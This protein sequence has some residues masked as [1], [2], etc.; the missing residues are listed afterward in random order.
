MECSY[1]WQKKNNSFS[2]VKTPEKE[3]KCEINEIKKNEIKKLFNEKCQS[4]RT[5][6]QRELNTFFVCYF[7]ILPRNNNNNNTLLQRMWNC[8]TLIFIIFTLTCNKIQHS[9]LVEC[10]GKRIFMKTCASVCTCEVFSCFLLYFN[11]QIF[12]FYSAEKI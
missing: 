4:V 8:I 11:R 5:N 6:R 9:V 7:L 1:V 3:H 2:Q 10:E 12:F